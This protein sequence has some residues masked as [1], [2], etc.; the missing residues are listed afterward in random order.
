MTLKQET[1]KDAPYLGRY[2]PYWVIPGLLISLLVF[3]I[4]L[5]WFDVVVLCQFRASNKGIELN[6]CSPQDIAKTTPAKQLNMPDSYFKAGEY[7]KVINLLEASILALKETGKRD[8]LLADNLQRV[9]KCYLMLG[10]YDKAEPY[11]HEAIAIY[12]ELSNAPKIAQN[13]A[14][15]DYAT[16]LKHLQLI[17]QNQTVKNK[18]D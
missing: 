18:E 3:W 10:K 5:F 1:I 14:N 12:S 17:E 8:A 13:Q 6:F 11:Y 9:G 7:E 2:T 16:V 15:K 4:F